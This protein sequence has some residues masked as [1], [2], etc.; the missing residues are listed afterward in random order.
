[1]PP[2]ATPPTRAT[3]PGPPP[4][5]LAPGRAG[6]GPRQLIT[7]RRFVIFRLDVGADG[8]WRAIAVGRRGHA[9]LDRLFDRLFDR[10]VVTARGAADQRDASRAIDGDLADPAQARDEPRGSGRP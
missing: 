7:R 1:M 5:D 6:P 8:R 4:G 3:P 10:R 9:L 2:A